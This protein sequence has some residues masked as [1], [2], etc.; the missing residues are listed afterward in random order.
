[1]HGECFLHSLCHDSWLHGSQGVIN[2]HI[3]SIGHFAALH[4]EGFEMKEDH[5]TGV[6]PQLP[7]AARIGW[8]RSMW[9]SRTREFCHRSRRGM[10]EKR[11]FVWRKQK[12]YI[13]N[14]FEKNEDTK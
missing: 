1:M 10:Q 9:E 6:S 2:A 8:I 11:T 14:F 5:V 13:Y 4:L 3:I 12:K 7:L